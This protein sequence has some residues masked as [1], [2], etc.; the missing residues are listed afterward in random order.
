MRLK[1]FLIFSVIFFFMSIS[2][3]NAKKNGYKIQFSNKPIVET[4]KSEEIKEKLVE[5]IN[6][7]NICAYIE[8][9]RN[10]DKCFESLE[11]CVYH[12]THNKVSLSGSKNILIM[13]NGRRIECRKK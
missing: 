9:G 10:H 6:P 12:Y 2:L 4:I 1:T 5:R 3:F 13:I 11:D 8:R 7:Q